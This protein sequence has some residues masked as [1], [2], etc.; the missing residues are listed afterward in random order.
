MDGPNVNLKFQESL[1]QHFE[2]TTGEK[3]LDIDT[4]TLHKVHSSFKKGVAL[5][6][7]DINQFAVDLHGFFKLPAACREDY[8]TMEELT[9]V[10]HLFDGSL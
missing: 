8:S 1:K 6:P 9:E 10:I 4:C 5:L 2:E 7:I 3:F